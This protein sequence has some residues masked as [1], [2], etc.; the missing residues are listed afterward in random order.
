[1]T[2]LIA[3]CGV[4]LLTPRTSFADPSPSPGKVAVQATFDTVP[5]GF[6]IFVPNESK[7]KNCE[8]IVSDD[9][10][11]SGAGCAELSSTDYA[12]YGIGP[13]DP[14]NVAP[15]E[16]WRVTAWLRAAPGTH[17]QKGTPGFLIRLGFYNDKK[18]IPG[19]YCIFVGVNGKPVLQAAADDLDAS[20]FGSELPS[21]WTKIEAVFEIPRTLG[22]IDGLFGP[23][24]FAW[25]TKGKLYIDDV[26][27]EKVAADTP[28]SAAIVPEASH[29]GPVTTDAEALAALDLDA[30]GM[31]KVKAAVQSGNLNAVKQAYLNYRRQD[32]PARWTIT[33]Q[34]RPAKPAAAD[35]KVG[36]EICSH[37][38]RNRYGFEPKAAFMGKD[39][40]WTLNP[41]PRG[42]PGYTDEW[43]F[44]AVSRTQFW[45]SL[46]DAYWATGNEKYAREWVA[47]LEDFIRK[48]PVD[49]KPS[50]GKASLWRTLDASERM[51][52]S[53]PDAYSHFLDSAAFDPSA[54]W[55]YLMSILDHAKLL[56]QGLETPGRAGNW[57]LSECYGL[58]TIGVLFPELKDSAQWRKIAIDRLTDELDRS[59]P[60]DGFEAELTP[61]YHYFSVS[62]FIGPLNLARINHLQVPDSFHSKVLQMY[63]APVLMMDQQGNVVPTNDSVEISAS[64]KAREGLRY[65]GDD[66]LL[67]WAA[68]NGREG[69]AP[70]TSDMLP[71]AGFYAMRGGWRPDDVFL[72]FRGGPAGI[73]HEHEDML[74]VV[75][76]AWK[77]TLLFD[78]GTAPY[79]HSD[80]RRFIL[81]TSSHSS[82]IVDG[83]WQHRGENRAPVPPVQN[84]WVTTPLFDYV[85]A[86]YDKGYQ[87]SVYDANRAFSPQQWVGSP[88]TSVSHTRRVLFLK[89]YYAL[90]LDTLDGTGQH[91]FDALFQVNDDSA[92]VDSATQAVFSA[93]QRG[94]H[95]A[96]YP[97]DTE[98]LKT[99]IV[100][101]QKNPLMGWI[102][103][104]K[105]IPTVRF[106]KQQDAPAVF[107]DFLYPFAN[108]APAFSSQA[109]AVEGTGVWARSL[110]TAQEDAEVVMTK[111]SAP[112]ELSFNSR[113]LEGVTCRAA[114]VVLRK[115]SGEAAAF[116]AA[117]KLTEWN[118]NG[119]SF[120][121]DKPASL[122]WTESADHI[123]VYNADSHPVS[124]T[125]GKPFAASANVPPGQWTEVSRQ[126]G[127]PASAPAMFA[128]LPSW[129]LAGL[130]YV[131]YLKAQPV[132]TDAPAANAPIH[133]AATTM[134]LP[135]GTVIKAKVG[136]DSAVIGWDE[137][138]TVLT[139]RVVV[140]ASG[141]YKLKIRY[142][143]PGEPARSILV[144]GKAPFAEAQ[145]FDLPSTE[146]APPSDGWSGSTNDWKEI[147][148]GEPGQAG[149]WKFCL[150]AGPMELS[151]RNDG[152]GGSNLDWVE[153]V[154]ANT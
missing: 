141:W 17:V 101:G 75:M 59:V 145:E 20:D 103:Q 84:P 121:S 19:A 151:L 55:L 40:D 46:A 85:A 154:P 14:V 60:P 88:D 6:G 13:K 2:G 49:A 76:R 127:A 73:G 34:D 123:L 28:L 119:W 78:P 81:G 18:E 125:I 41:I 54:Q 3:A 7:D 93:G 32:C 139:T 35:D 8:F 111:N 124:L 27:L 144:N 152:G 117:G 120:T 136:A 11:H 47:E 5:S 98:H 112:G 138:G 66:P 21:V 16:R 1:M 142:C 126:G 147:Y 38:I 23:S 70:P 45:E 96:I 69:V 150:P 153:L 132:P 77:K 53:W 62:S 10:P 25:R 68:T 114:E 102:T 97:L 74:E 109:L 148:A 134:V 22:P 99:D 135:P 24:L 50:K 89:P 48:N 90:I 51:D 91:K 63:R 122:T 57:V 87:Q 108:D 86:T 130:S 29:E 82:I 12:R 100:Q 115:P 72:F 83:K 131:D 116:E 67:K 43:T 140:P 36:D 105:A 65:L 113:W 107:A 37:Y 118:D 44:C 92:H 95:L 9:N 94:P 133:I 146:G 31:E 129:K 128:P 15:G 64:V 30:P 26:T 42:N 71:Y 137:A 143:T 52:E 106:S 56:R 4:V 149:G 79:D 39:F 61:T 104:Q 80:W 58:Y 33:P 110:H